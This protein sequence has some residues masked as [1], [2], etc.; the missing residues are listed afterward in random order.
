MTVRLR[1][2]HLLCT[3]TYVG[4]GYSTG[5]ARNM[6]EVISR[7]N[8]GEP[9]LVVEGPD[10]ICAPLLQTE[11]PHCLGASVRERDHAAAL[12]IS[13]ATD[14]EIKPGRSIRLTP[15][16]IAEFRTSFTTGKT[17][18][19]CLGCQWSRLF[20][21]VSKESFASSRLIA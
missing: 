17:R 12:S 3:L 4:H 10:D 7:M 13:R 21:S 18:K 15:D 9:V 16:R 8:H 6:D 5:F 1:P 19:A 11:N 20:T 14:L 2:H